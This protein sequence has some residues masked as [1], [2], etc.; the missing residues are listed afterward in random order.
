MD[1]QIRCCP[2]QIC[3][4]QRNREQH[5]QIRSGTGS[6][7]APYIYHESSGTSNP[8]NRRFVVTW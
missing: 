1:Q 3:L 2:P 6:P 7:L 8:T 5:P 4:R